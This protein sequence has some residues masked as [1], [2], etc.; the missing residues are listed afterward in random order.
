MDYSTAAAFVV[1]AEAA[2]LVKKRSDVWTTGTVSVQ[3][4]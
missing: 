4:T 1:L 3:R 2:V